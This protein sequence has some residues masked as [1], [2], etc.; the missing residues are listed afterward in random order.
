M[1]FFLSIYY[2][3]T[4][5]CDGFLKWRS[6]GHHRLEGSGPPANSAP[7]L[8]R[9]AGN[10]PG[11]LSL[12]NPTATILGCGPHR[13]S[14][15]PGR[16]WAAG[17]FSA[18]ALFE[19]GCAYHHRSR[20]GLRRCTRAARRNRTWRHA[21]GENTRLAV[22]A[23][24]SG[25]SKDCSANANSWKLRQITQLVVLGGSSHLVSGLVH[26]SYKWINPTYPMKITRVN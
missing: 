24:N 23:N 13:P 6:L 7:V 21:V 1:G 3:G 26:P 11:N 18:L 17:F 8:S 25:K 4:T 10:W 9:T 22:A 5:L 2:W 14:Q 19:N 20:S 16:S 15:S 12:E